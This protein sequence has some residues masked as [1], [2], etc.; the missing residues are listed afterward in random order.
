[1]KKTF[2]YSLLAILALTGCQ[3][4]EL[5]SLNDEPEVILNEDSKVFTAIIDDDFNPETRTTLDGEG[6]VLWKMGDQ[7]SIFAGSTVNEQYQVTDASD[8]KTAASL[9]KVGGGGFVAGTEIDNNVAFYPYASTA[10]IAKSGGNYVISGVELPAT[11]NYA[12]GSFGNGAFP[13]VAVTSS[14]E[15]MNLKF[16]NILG[17]LKLQLKGTATIASITITGNNN[18]KLYGDADVTVANGSTPSISL[19][20]AS[21]KTVTLDCGA[22]VALDAETA[23]PFIIALP[24]ITMTGGF[25]V[26][27][28]DAEGKQMEISTSKSQTI[29]RS[30]L[31]RM[32]AV[33]Y[34]GSV[35][36][37][38]YTISTSAGGTKASLSGTDMVWSTG[39]KVFLT[40]GANSALCTIPSTYDGLTTATVKTTQVLTG[41]ITCIYPGDAVTDEGSSIYV[42]VPEDQGT[43]GSNYMVYSGSSTSSTIDL[44][45]ATAL[46]KVRLSSSV[47][48][49]DYIKITFYGAP[50][51]GRLQISELGN[52]VI[53]GTQSVQVSE[54]G[55]DEYLFSVLPGTITS[56]NVDIVKTD[57]TIGR[58]TSSSS[59]TISAGTLSNY[60]IDPATVSFEYPLDYF[61]LTSTGSTSVDLNKV[62]SP[63][64]IVL[65]YRKN[66]GAWTSYT[67]G[68]SVSL[69]DG[70]TLQFRSDED[71]NDTFSQG[72]SNYYF[73]EATGTGTISASGNIMSLLDRSLESVTVPQNAFWW[74][75]KSCSKLVGASELELPATSLADYCY[76]GMFQSCSNLETAPALPA[77]TLAIFSYDHMFSGCASLSSAPALPATTL[78]YSCYGNMFN[79]CS[80]LTSAPE[81]PAASIVAFCYEYMFY[82]CT[83]LTSAPELPATFVPN[84]SYQYMFSGCT[85]LTTAPELPA[86][87]LSDECYKGMFSG[88]SKLNY[89]K[90]LFT[91]IPPYSNQCLFE[92]LYGVSATGT[93]VKSSSA[94][95]DVTGVSGV[96]DGWTV[97][98]E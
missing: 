22:G 66:E 69:S 9:N 8:G 57:G 27:V 3:T 39:D 62:G 45:P 38:E 33:N 90:A 65:E 23:T 6:N 47:A 19:T 5:D 63:A 52:S 54:N 20:D 29:T 46:F 32:P 96:P 50:V 87:T 71:G 75:F 25:T 55:E 14:T 15:D 37:Y 77:T 7:V 26:V 34:V 18:E 53:S 11:Q 43:N 94:T 30:N 93:F 2:V 41:T 78:S 73:I 97:E 85:N 74:L 60:H 72:I 84:N 35:P 16:K 4:K 49:L 59:R 67:I 91:T 80:S 28:T 83:S 10:E 40:D 61:T 82:G 64:D 24:P 51:V 36:E 13:M 17:G 58:K 92:W 86:S 1:M 81:L 89:V 95:W 12:A 42:D 31:L 88:C 68:S 98:T 76:Y 21:A 48:D 56:V 44:S 79:G 70:E